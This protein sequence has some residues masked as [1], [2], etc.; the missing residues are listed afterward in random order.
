MPGNS[1]AK[2]AQPTI[3]DAHNLLT[4]RGAQV[5]DPHGRAA[6]LT[7]TVDLFSEETD[8]AFA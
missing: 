1:N 5:R 7:E 8:V 6:Y 3:A 4:L 2:P